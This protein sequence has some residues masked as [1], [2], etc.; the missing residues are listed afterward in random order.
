[1]DTSIKVKLKN[2]ERLTGCFISMFSQ[3]A[4]EIIAN[5]G[6]DCVMIDLEHGPGNHTQAIAMM[7]AAES[8]GCCPLIRAS[9][10]N[11]VDIKRILDI[12]PMGIMVPDIRTPAQAR[13][14][15]AHCRYAP[16]GDRGAA[17]GYMRAMDYSGFNGQARN[18][19]P[20]K[21]FMQDDFLLIAQVESAEGLAS[22]EEIAR[23]D[24]IDMIFIGPADL[25]ASLGAL[26][27]FDSE[28]FIDAF[29]R[30]EAATLGAGKTLGCIPFADWN[31]A[32]LFRN[33]HQLVISAADALLL[34]KAANEDAAKVR[35][36]A[37]EH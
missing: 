5:A 30:I 12:G 6:Y 3:I 11:I 8:R 16:E 17:P 14:V 7:Q 20:Y 19:K 10:A 22:I 23:V 27:T 24:G 18:G 25:S 15:V 37:R 21:T 34:A 33:G 26:G 28:S 32:R 35:Q 1:M 2:G 29:D 31:P 9:S 4:T 36:D 13:E